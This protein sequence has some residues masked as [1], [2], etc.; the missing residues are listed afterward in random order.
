MAVK[1]GREDEFVTENE[2]FLAEKLDIPIQNLVL[3]KEEVL[4]KS[5]SAYFRKHEAPYGNGNRQS[6]NR[7]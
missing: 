6:V 1:R 3:Y 7:I 4:A 2:D 5:A